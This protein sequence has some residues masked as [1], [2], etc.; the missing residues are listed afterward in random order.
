[1]LKWLST[2]P[3]RHFKA[4][5]QKICFFCG[6]RI[7]KRN[8][9]SKGV[10]R[11]K[12]YICK[13]TFVGGN[14]LISKDVWDEYTKG[15]Q[16]YE[17]LGSKHCCSTKTIQRKID[18][19]VLEQKK[20]FE[21]VANV[22][23]DTTYFGRTFGVMVFKNSLSGEILLKYY[24]KVETNNQYYKGIEEIARRGIK[25][26]SIICDGRKGLFQM[27]GGIPVQM[28]QFHQTQI[29]TRYLTKNPKLEA[30]KELRML[31][32]RITKLSKK[33]FV[34]ELDKWAVKW[35]LFIKERTVSSTTGKSYFTHKTLRSAYLSL[36]RNMPWLF[37]FEQY[38]EM[39]IPNTTNAL[40]G[41]FSDLKNKL[42]N[43][44]GLTL[45]RKKKFIDGFFKV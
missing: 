20:C 37:V 18:S 28:C 22:L 26:Q 27:F 24:V 35:D 2:L 39:K 14:R 33:E 42:R 43:H 40:D 11:Y 16:T 30:S 41:L 9:H 8:G 4:Y 36:K 38:Q 23:I 7:T 6:S 17:Q 21:S 15:K 5:E 29:I 25:I 45:E 13:R 10:Q 3:L 19:V 1:M 31:S 32:L 44:N 12:C 34:I